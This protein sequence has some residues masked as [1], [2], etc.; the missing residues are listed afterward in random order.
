MKAQISKLEHEAEIAEKQTDYNK[1]AEIKYS[2]IPELQKKIIETEK[3]IE[4]AKN[5]GK[6]LLKDSVDAEDIAVI[7]AKRTEIP[8]SKLIESEAEKL[9][10]LESYLQQKVVGQKEAVTVVSN[11]IRRARA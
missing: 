10:H 3:S 7:I 1:V 6:I 2:K 9:T 5:E 11:A 4:S 8:V